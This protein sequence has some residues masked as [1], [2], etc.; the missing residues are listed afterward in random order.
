MGAGFLEVFAELQKLFAEWQKL[1]PCPGRFF[2]LGGADRGRLLASPLKKWF[3]GKFWVPLAL[4]VLL[5][6]GVF[7]TGKASGTLF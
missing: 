6:R 4:P 2:C 3:C 7:N 1:E 5:S